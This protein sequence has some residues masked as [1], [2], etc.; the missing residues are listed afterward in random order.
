MAVTPQE[1]QALY[2]ALVKSIFEGV[3]KVEYGDKKV[4]YRSL[5]EMIRIKQMLEAELGVG[6]PSKRTYASFSKGTHPNDC[7]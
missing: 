5:N 3:L 4:E 2:D 6:R 7:E 1:K